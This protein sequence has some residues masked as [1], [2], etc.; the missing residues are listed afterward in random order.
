[1]KFLDP[2][3]QTILVGVAALTDLV[4]GAA[5][6]ANKLF[7][8]GKDKFESATK[9][10][11]QKAEGSAQKNYGV[12]GDAFG[13]DQSIRNRAEM[14]AGGIVTGPTNALVGE[15]GPEAVIPLSGNSPQIKV[16]N[17]E[18]N[19]LLKQLIRKTPEMAPLGLYEVQ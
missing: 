16:D 13:E 3:I 14:A 8:D 19:A 5:F 12:S 4:K 2:M 1:M 10:Q 9:K 7:G 11:I 6:L 17:S 18:T 15:A